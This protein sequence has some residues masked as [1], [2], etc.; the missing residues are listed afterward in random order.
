MSRRV[1][2]A[3][4][5]IALLLVAAA[6]ATVVSGTTQLMTVTSNVEGAVLYMDG[7]RVGSTPFTGTVPKNKDQLRVEADG[8]RSETVTLS[9]QLEPI[10]WGNIIIGGTLGSITDFASGAAYQYAPATYQVD[11]Q[12]AG[13]PEAEY[14]NQLAVRKFSMV[15]VDRIS[16]DVSRGSGDYLSALL[17]LIEYAGAEGIE[18]SAVRDAL[19]ASGGDAVRF[20]KEAVALIQ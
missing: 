5:A 19:A 11:L 8:Y 18:P 4:T 9:K 16:R 17:D 1:T 15:Y 3:G 2:Q 20:G 13:Q 6:C 10:F 14:R 12:R 7:E